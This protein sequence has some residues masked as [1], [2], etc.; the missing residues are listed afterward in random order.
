MT[1]EKVPPRSPGDS[2]KGGGGDARQPNLST[3]AALHAGRARLTLSRGGLGGT[4]V[5]G[6]PGPKKVVSARGWRRRSGQQVTTIHIPAATTAHSDP[7]GHVRT[8]ACGSTAE[9]R[10]TG[11][12]LRPLV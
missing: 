10:S 7:K 1:S 12:L 5:S 6:A 8:E 4:I 9:T 3:L 2:H 11:C